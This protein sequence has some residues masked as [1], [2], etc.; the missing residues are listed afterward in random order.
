MHLLQ[1]LLIAWFA[2][3]IVSVSLLFWLCKRTAAA[4]V[5]ADKLLRSPRAD[6]NSVNRAA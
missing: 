1:W 3:G 5:D 2:L 6:L 4:I